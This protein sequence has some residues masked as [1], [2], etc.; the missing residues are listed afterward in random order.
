MFKAEGKEKVR[1]GRAQRAA[2]VPS[3][4]PLPTRT[5]APGNYGPDC[6]PERGLGQCTFPPEVVGGLTSSGGD[7]STGPSIFEDMDEKCPFCC[8][9]NRVRKS[10]LLRT[11][12]N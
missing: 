9:L 3:L 6:Q 7:W 2:F 11:T 5:A 12:S 10:V 8:P 1:S 4:S